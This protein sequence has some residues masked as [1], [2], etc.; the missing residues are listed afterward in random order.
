MKHSFFIT[1]LV[2]SLASHSAFAQNKFQRTPTVSTGSSIDISQLKPL[3]NIKK[4]V[5]PAANVLKNLTEL[6]FK[7]L[8]PPTIARPEQPNLRFSN[9]SDAQPS[10]VTGSLVAT[11]ADAR[12][13][14]QTYLE[15]TQYFWKIKN[16]TSE[17]VTKK[18]ETDDLGVTHT[19]LQ[20]Q[21]KGVDV[22]GGEL[23]AHEKNGAIFM[24]N[25]NTFPTPTI[26]NIVPA[27]SPEQAKQAIR[28]DVSRV[29]KLKTLTDAE[30]KL[31]K[32]DAE[33]Q[34]IIWHDDKKTPVLVWHWTIVPNI[35]D[36]WEYFADAK[37]GKILNKYN[38]V[39][40]FA[41]KENA[42]HEYHKDIKL[43]KNNTLAPP[44][45]DGPATANATDLL[46]V[47]RL[48]N[49]YQKGSAYYMIDISRPMYQATASTMPNDPI[50]AIWTLDAMNTSPSGNGFQYD[51]VTSSNNSWNNA[52]AISAHYNGGVAYTYYKNTFN[53]NSINGAGGTII[54]LINV[55]DD[56]GGG[57]DNAFWNGEAMFYGNGS[58]AFKPLARGLD[59]AGHEMSHGVIQST[60][61]LNYQGE[62]GA[63][64]E[65]FADIFGAM[66]DRNDWQMGED[67]V[68]IGSFP[69]GALRDLSN[70]HN[71]GSGLGSP[72]WQ[73]QSYSERYTG[74]QDNGGVHINSGIPN[75]AYY[76]FANNAAVGK[77]KGEQVFYRALTKYLTKSSKF[78]DLRNAVI[79]S[80]AD[81][82][83]GAA[84]N[85]AAVQAFDA[86]GIAGGSGGGTGGTNYQTSI[87]P[88]PGQ[89]L[90][91]YSDA[92]Q[93]KIFISNPAGT[94]PTVLSTT[95]HISKP[96]VSDD[97][98]EVVFIG[99]DKKIH[100]IPIDWAAGSFG[101]EEIIS[102]DP[103]WKNA[104]LSKDGY[105]LAA[106]PE[107][108]VN[109][110]YTYDFNAV[111]NPW[112]LFTLYNPTY[113]DGITTGD[114]KFADALEW[115]YS[116]NNVI[117][118]SYNEIN[119]G[120]APVN[121]WDV[122]ILRAYNKSAGTFGDGKIQ[123]LFSSL[124][125]GI[126]IGDPTF[127]KNSPSVVAVDYINQDQ[128]QYVV[129]GINI[130]NGT[131]GTIYQNNQPGYPNYSRLDNKLIFGT[132]NNN[133]DLLVIAN[134]A[135]DKI[136]A[137]GTPATYKSNTK[138]GV[139][140]ANG[141]R[142]LT[143]TADA[144]QPNLVKVFPNPTSNQLTIV[145]QEYFADS[146]Y[147][148]YNILGEKIS[149]QKLSENTTI[150]ECSNFADGIYFLHIFGNGKQQV[151]KVVKN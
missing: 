134:M 84:V 101:P 142:V 121:Y 19:W 119:N 114:V 60:A 112:K 14:L 126:S 100:Y 137:T 41:H 49:T 58:Q 75:F 95:A 23:I 56:N 11:A 71:G 28:S 52:T 143:A 136:N 82:N 74:S 141:T 36:R 109:Q 149:Q 98:S 79:Q 35:L 81:L 3:K 70:P 138:W 4:G 76:K 64:N 65:S 128:D 122:G 97:G 115:D 18:E 33:P 68:K 48:I 111:A 37:T 7:T 91:L 59:V 27:V 16:V 127:S 104:A 103:I 145:Q 105:Q 54:S 87:P 51:H 20:Q 140:F 113:T 39:C 96:S 108:E 32:A 124:P 118:D 125:N 29:S 147:E 46:G 44:P 93:T 116:G 55:A 150:V 45:L 47:T 9:S 5:P 133:T 86:V 92:G 21:Y 12:L 61:N 31:V 17:F 69:S 43:E 26:S 85:T 80:I 25:G 2:L 151:I 106:V 107:Q 78:T 123:K 38:N 30:K 63:L 83:Y 88:N 72:G 62:S 148:L 6:N 129:I 24:L 34:L 94:S 22:W 139:W 57:L 110:I 50:G 15:A 42:H 99:T 90:I 77:D 117:Y 13:Q 8:P 131:T 67:V 130:E 1:F 120:S 144:E 10:M 132:N 102:D 135:A 53:R 73:P 146:R 66:I 89:D 40:R